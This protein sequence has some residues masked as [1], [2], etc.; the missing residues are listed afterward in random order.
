MRVK[1]LPAKKVRFRV[2]R[3]A[4]PDHAS[5]A[6]SDHEDLEPTAEP[7]FDSCTLT[8]SLYIRQQKM[9]AV[10]QSPYT[11]PFKRRQ[12]KKFTKWVPQT[13]LDQ[14]MVDQ[15]NA[16]IAVHGDDAEM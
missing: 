12:S 3:G 8:P 10:L 4:V 1:H 15:L 16:Y 2:R 5:D 7:D 14:G 6:S 13:N 9:A 11:N